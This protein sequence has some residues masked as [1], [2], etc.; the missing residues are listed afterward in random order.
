[1]TALLKD[2]L[3]VVTGG[4]S[5]IGRGIALAAARH[6]AR[7]VVIAD[8]QPDPKEGGAT[9]TSL[10]EEMGT[11]A[12][13]CRVDVT[14]RAD[15]DALVADTLDLGGVDVMVCNAGIALP[16][17]GCDI[18]EEDFHQLLRVNL[19]GVLFSAQAAAAQMRSLGKQG[20]IVMTGSMGGIRGA[21]VTVGYSTTKGGVCLMAASLADALGPDG[22]R[23]NAVCPGL[24][25][26]SLINASPGVAKAAQGLVDRMPLRRLGQPSEVGDAVAW[27]GSDC[28]SF[29]TGVSLAV[30]G[31][32]TAII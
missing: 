29:V 3:I 22:I 11:I 21:A 20:S 24:I 8:L 9:T 26:T 1:M 19:D 23:V 16:R 15:M 28:S 5:G 12:R 25:D 7:A 14:S 18:S 13:F 4:A 32:L 6:S 10:L 27:L 17:D 2:K 31:G 30:D